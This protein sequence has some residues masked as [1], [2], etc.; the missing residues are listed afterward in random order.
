MEFCPFLT[1]FLSSK[2]CS[3]S[4]P[5]SFHGLFPNKD[6]KWIHLAWE[7]CHLLWQVR[8]IW[9]TSSVCEHFMYLCWEQQLAGRSDLRLQ[10]GV[11]VFVSERVWKT[12]NT[13]FHWEA[14]LSASRARW[15]DS[16][17]LK[18]EGEK[19]GHQ[20]RQV[21]FMSALVIP[22]IALL[23]RK[24]LVWLCFFPRLKCLYNYRVDWME[25]PNV[26]GRCDVTSGTGKTDLR[27]RKEWRGVF[28][29]CENVHATMFW[30]CCCWLYW[31]R[32]TL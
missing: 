32:I 6:I 16:I 7:T 23:D 19:V 5:N 28:L 13:T 8:N 1:G 3:T 2:L 24:W 21:T 9:D 15:M 10:V 18:G 27:G 30:C 11:N 12:E 29:V 26:W 31:P 25:T 20:T 4:K 17:K 22:L 14:F